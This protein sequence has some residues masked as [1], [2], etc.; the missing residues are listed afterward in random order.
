MTSAKSISTENRLDLLIAQ[1]G[2]AP[3]DVVVPDITATG[4]KHLAHMT[5]P[6]GTVQ[7]SE[8]YEG[9]GHGTFSTGNPAPTAMTFTVYADGVGSGII[10]QLAVPAGGLWINAAGA[11][12]ICQFTVL[13]LDASTASC[14]LRIWW[15]TATG[16]VG[17][18]VYFTVQNLG[19]IDT[20]AD[21]DLTLAFGFTGTGV[22]FRTS[23]VHIYRVA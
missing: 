11:G 10:A 20:S 6:G 13:W 2:P 18:V 8:R 5:I 21:R 14:S 12:W 4:N 16:A 3:A 1:S 9:F 22:T 7:G 19:S 17:S 15:H 23:G